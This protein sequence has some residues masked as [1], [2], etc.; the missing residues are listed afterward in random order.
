MKLLA[1]FILK[2]CGWK[3][4]EQYPDVKKS[5]CIVAPHTSM[6]DFVFGKLYFMA[7]G[8]KPRFLIKSE[9]F[10][11]YLGWFLRSLG[12]VP[13]YRKSPVGLVDQMLHYFESRREFTLVITPEA[14]RSKVKKWKTGAIRI[15]S[16]AK[17]PL[18]LGRVD[19]KKKE[20]GLVRIY[21]DIPGDKNFINQLK[22]DFKGINARHPEKFDPD[23]EQ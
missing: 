1:R 19:Y 16:Q 6:W 2:L 18:V 23:Y 22:K 12:G 21:E 7:L 15:A 14:T 11:W 9:M 5:V 3:I 13:V 17:V 4:R 10:T 8:I 20:M